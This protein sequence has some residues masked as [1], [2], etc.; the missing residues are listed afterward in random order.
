MSLLLLLGLLLFR[1]QLSDPLLVQTSVQAKVNGSV[2]GQI[3]DPS[4][5]TVP[6]VEIELVN[7]SGQ[8]ISTARTNAEGQYQFQSI[9]VGN[10]QIASTE[11]GAALA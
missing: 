8:I 3:T 11:Y 9:P 5:A 1:S 7:Q 4:G 10:S 2:V 6:N